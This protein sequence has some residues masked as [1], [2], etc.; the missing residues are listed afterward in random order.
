MTLEGRYDLF[1]SFYVTLSALRYSFSH[2]PV[3]PRSC[4]NVTIRNLEKAS[5]STLSCYTEPE[6]INNSHVTLMA[7]N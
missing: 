5:C 6:H 2:G 7:H 3:P 4:L 1:G